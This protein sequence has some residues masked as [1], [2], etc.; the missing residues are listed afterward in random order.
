MKQLYRKKI[1]F[2]PS[3]TNLTFAVIFGL[4][5]DSQ[6]PGTNRSLPCKNEIKIK[7]TE[8]GLIL[9]T[10]LSNCLHCTGLHCFQI[11][12]SACYYLLY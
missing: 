2:T 7:A 11:H 6:I 8:G 12:F 1:I 9:Y 3:S 10:A 5:T 4:V